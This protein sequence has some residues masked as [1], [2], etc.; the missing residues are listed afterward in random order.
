MTLLL[1]LMMSQG[2]SASE[3]AKSAFDELQYAKAESEAQRAIRSGQLK[4]PQL[5]SMLE[6]SAVSMA[7]QKRGS[8]AKDVFSYLLSVFPG[9]QVPSQFGPKVRAPFLEAK[10]ASQATRVQ[11]TNRSAP[12]DSACTVVITDPFK[13]VETIS[14][15]LVDGQSE[16]AFEKSGTEMTH[17]QPMSFPGP[18]SVSG[19]RVD[20][21]DRY[22]NVV[23]QFP[24]GGGTWPLNVP[25]PKPEVVQDT[26]IRNPNLPKA[27]A[28]PLLTRPEPGPVVE[29]SSGK[30]LPRVLAVVA[31]VIAVGAFTGA[32]VLGD[33]SK[34][35]DRI[36]SKVESDASGRVTSLSQVRADELVKQSAQQALLANVLFGIGGA[37]AAGG[38][39]ALGFSF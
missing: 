38:A 12:T 3:K 9:Y 35:P 34:A 11:L 10:L 29:Q 7:M 17:D 13:Y 20:L 1:V 31:G 4:V 23:A 21:K 5:R 6:I 22:G 33:A 24:E 37:S 30:T 18:K 8:S 26:S 16:T 27:S 39:V 25:V 15:V 14:V 19:C 36:A 32:A 2:S 28:D